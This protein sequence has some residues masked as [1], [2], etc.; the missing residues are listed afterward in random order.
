M[1]AGAL[2]GQDPEVELGEETREV[3]EGFVSVGLGLDP[4]GGDDLDWVF[5]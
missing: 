3:G 4:K 1:G 5:F 2:V